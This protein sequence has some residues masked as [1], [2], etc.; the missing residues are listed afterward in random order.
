MAVKHFS[1]DED[2]V[3]DLVMTLKPRKEGVAKPREAKRT[4]KAAERKSRTNNILWL[5]PYADDAGIVSQPLVSHEKMMA[6]IVTACAEF[7]PTVSEPHTEILRPQ[8][9]S[10]GEVTFRVSTPGKVYMQS[11]RLC[12]Y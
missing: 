3:A 8:A 4:P 1:T 5:V 12:T 2:A 10:A 11:K 7:S 6:A 9:K